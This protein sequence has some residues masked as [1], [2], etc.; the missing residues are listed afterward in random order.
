MKLLIIRSSEA[1]S[2][3]SC[4]VISPNLQKTY[5]LLPENFVLSWFDIPINYVQK[6]INSDR[7]II[8]ELAKR[9]R[10]ESPDRIIFVDHLPCP[11]DIL[12]KLSFMMELKHL[13]PLV[14]HIYG[15]FTHFSKAWLDISEKIIN[16]PLKFIVA[17]S[18]QKKLLT[19]F[20]EDPIN[21]NQLCFPVNSEDYYFSPRDRHEFR[22]EHHID[23]GDT[24]VLYA[25]RISLQKNVDVLIQEYLNLI[26]KESSTVH[27][28]V[29]G[30][31]DDM[32][33]PFMGV[34]SREGY[35]HS[36]IQTILGN[37]PKELTKNIKF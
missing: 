30:A 24:V 26:K 11:A 4:K 3:G 2:W 27:L 19:F 37:H 17:S 31:F 10:A 13:P 32:G 6:E 20:C 15:D 8:S 33:A 14:F 5:E 22:D 12:I 34:K 9:I 29:V 16:H 23:E 1:S 35:L 28:W 18:S 7:S 25:G 21:L 36:K